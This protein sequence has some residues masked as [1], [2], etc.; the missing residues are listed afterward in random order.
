MNTATNGNGAYQEEEETRGRERGREGSDAAQGSEGGQ[1]ES[2]TTR[3]RRRSRKGLERKFECPHPGCGKFYSRAEHLYRHQLNHQPKQI[4]FCDFPECKRSFVRQ[5]LC[6]RHRERHTNRGSHLQRKDHYLNNPAP[7][8]VK[9]VQERRGSMVSKTSSSPEM[10]TN[11]GMI[12]RTSGDSAPAQR[13]ASMGMQGQTGEFRVNPST[14]NDGSTIGSNGGN[15]Q[16]L[17]LSIPPQ[18]FNRPT[19]LSVTTPTNNM[20]VLTLQSPYSASATNS[21]PPTPFTA[22]STGP[23]IVASSGPPMPSRN[24]STAGQ[25]QPQQFT[26]QPGYQPFS[27]P[28]PAYPNLST[29]P[30]TS[31][32]GHSYVSTGPTTSALDPNSIAATTASMELDQ[33]SMQY[34]LPV[35]GDSGYS[36]SPQWGHMAGMAGDWLDMLMADQA[37]GS[38]QP[39]QESFNNPFFESIGA[40]P[41]DMYAMNAPEFPNPFFNNG[42]MNTHPMNISTIAPPSPPRDS[43][44]S[45]EKRQQLIYQIDSF[46][47]VTSMFPGGIVSGPAAED[48]RHPLSLSMMQ[49]YI[50]LYW[51]HFH[52]QLPILHRPTFSAE[53]TPDILLLCILIIGAA[54]MDF[55]QD[56]T[57]AQ[58]AA[59]L[60]N[61]ISRS[62]RWAI[63]ATDDFRPPAKLWVLQ[64]LLL[65]ETFEKMYSDRRLHERAHIH[66]ATTLTLM[67]RGSSLTGRSGAYDSPQSGRDAKSTSNDSSVT[68][69]GQP[70]AGTS[71]TNDEAWNRWIVQEATKRIAFAAFV[72][73]STHATMFG[74]SAVMVAHEMRLQLPC[75]ETLWAATSASEV[76]SIQQSLVQ[77]NV[78]TPTFLEGLKKTLTG[79]TV[80]TNSF[81]RTILMAGLLSVGWHL[82]QRDV[83][84][85]SLGVVQQLGGKEKWRTTLT[86]SF[87]HWRKDFDNALAKLRSRYDGITY[88]ATE[89]VEHENIFESRT[90]LHHLAHMSMHVDIVDLQI[91]A[92]AR[93]LLGRAITRN[94]SE[95]T[96]KRMKNWAPTARAR[97]A[98]FYGLRFLSQVLLPEERVDMQYNADEDDPDTPGSRATSGPNSTTG[99]PVYSAR[100]DHLLNRPWVLYYACL[101]VWSYGYALEG[102][103][104]KPV[105]IP[106][107]PAESYAAMRS[108]LRTTG[109]LRAPEELASLP[110]K[111]ACLGLLLTLQGMFSHCR[112]E[113]LLEA[114]KLLKNCVAITTGEV[115]N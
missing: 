23:P 94:D 100:D 42:N 108:Y 46:S 63:F 115:S 45:D 96:R 70:G 1:N 109:G 48:E 49:T 104:E 77:N 7:A 95:F 37:S 26:T 50:S 91:Y 51:V 36:R 79:H 68:F 111:N 8:I 44:L 67:R 103:L 93:R 74:H 34:T 4:Y 15:P 89:D 40:A 12:R 43:L 76:F 65:L 82:H 75:D 106:S 41:Q 73:D 20:H 16:I 58:E 2:P 57:L 105:V 60:A 39:R 35:F 18:Q 86:L 59:D 3:K 78:H 85:S 66:H 61:I 9:S 22:N 92:G 33:M 97:D 101:V 62:L 84:V 102:P 14:P 81:G 24:N 32:S 55:K 6:A 11:P 112:W 30:T 54:C 88:Y 31:A 13:R 25:G 21:A 80:S 64:A 69:S 107:S 10:A 17:P 28:Q 47:E 114:S 87:D 56:P 52:P 5:D 83:Q 99:V 110:N 19:P 113:L 90:V 27:L 53:K 29:Q 38:G 98:A 71:N 72:V